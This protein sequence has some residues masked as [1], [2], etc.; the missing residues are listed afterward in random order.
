MMPGYH[1]YFVPMS[2]VP[3]EKLNEEC[4]ICY[5]PLHSP[6]SLDLEPPTE[7]LVHEADARSQAPTLRLSESPT[8]DLNQPLVGSQNQSQSQKKL[9]PKRLMVTPCKHYFHEECLMKWFEKK[10]E[11][12]LCRAKTQ[13]Y[14]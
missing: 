5:N 12:P 10:S 11:C 13:F 1:N 8:P 9:P 2:K 14:G 3:T 6:P 7:P 4:S